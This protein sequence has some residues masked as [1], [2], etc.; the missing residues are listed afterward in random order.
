MEKISLTRKTKFCR[1]TPDSVLKIVK[2]SFVFKLV[3]VYKC[4]FFASFD[5]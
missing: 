2:S 4:V 3:S 1:L 5:V